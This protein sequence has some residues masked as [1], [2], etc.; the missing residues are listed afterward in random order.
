MISLEF[1]DGIPPNLMSGW[2]CTDLRLEGIIVLVY[3]QVVAE[4]EEQSSVCGTRVWDSVGE[5]E[6]ENF[7][8]VN[9]KQ[10]GD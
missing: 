8:T 6:T 7:E 1:T 3:K 9:R 4:R 2:E 10:H 5:K